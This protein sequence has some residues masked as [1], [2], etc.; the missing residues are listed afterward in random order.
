[1]WL[2]AGIYCVH[3]ACITSTFLLELCCTL[4]QNMG[5]DLT[6]MEWSL[7]AWKFDLIGQRQGKNR[8]SKFRMETTAFK[9]EGQD[10]IS[11]NI[12]YTLST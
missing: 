1:M 10:F 8:K 7:L 11:N 3:A 9:P 12:C 5:R 2:N 4:T 6:D